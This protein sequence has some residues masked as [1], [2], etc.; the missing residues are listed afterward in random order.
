MT[1]IATYDQ[2]CGHGSNCEVIR[3]G[4]PIP[5]TGTG[6]ANRAEVEAALIRAGVAVAEADWPVHQAKTQANWDWATEFVTRATAE[7]QRG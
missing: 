1:I 4:D 5:A 3:R 2:L 6:I 7:G